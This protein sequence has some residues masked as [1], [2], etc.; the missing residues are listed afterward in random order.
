M[1]LCTCPVS[2]RINF[3][4]PC[5]ADPQL[6]TTTSTSLLL[7]W[8]KVTSFAVRICNA[9]HLIPGTQK[10]GG[11]KESP[12]STVRLSIEY[13]SG[14]TSMYGQPGCA[15]SIL[16]PFFS[17]P[18]SSYS[19]LEAVRYCI[20]KAAVSISGHVCIVLNTAE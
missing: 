16:F 12:I 11:R 6:T 15:R 14:P 4:D 8:S 2:T 9:R 18:F 5:S 20:E 3:F 7:S 1:M 13:V 17:L 10:E 19:F